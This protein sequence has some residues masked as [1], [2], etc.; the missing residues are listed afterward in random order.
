MIIIGIAALPAA[1]AWAAWLGRRLDNTQWGEWLPFT[2]AIGPLGSL[3]LGFLNSVSSL[4]HLFRDVAHVVNR[5]DKEL[6]LETG[7]PTALTPLRNSL[8]VSGALYAAS[9]VVMGVLTVIHWRNPARSRGPALG[10]G[11]R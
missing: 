5:A 7:L 11:G 2:V 3:V 1:I 4:M 6:L 10:R 8:V 9:V